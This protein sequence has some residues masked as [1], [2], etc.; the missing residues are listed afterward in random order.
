MVVK[1]IKSTFYHESETKN[2]LCDFIRKAGQL[3]MG[4]ECKKFEAAFAQKQQRKYSVFVS[5][6]S[7]ANLV[8]LQAL[9]NLGRLKK[10]DRVGVSSVTWATNVMPV[11]QLGLD[12]VLIDCELDT[13]NVSSA[14]L[15]SAGKGLK[16]LFLTNVLG[17]CSD[18]DKIALYCKDQGIILLEDNCESLGSKYKGTLLG[19]FGVASTFSFF[20]GHHLSTI[21]GG[22]VCTDDEDLAEML[23]IVRA[24][25]WDR[26]LSRESQQRIRSKH[27]ID[28]FFALYTFYDLAYNARPTEINGFIGNVQLPYWDEI[29]KKRH[30]NFM[31]IRKCCTDRDIFPLKNDRMD[32]ISNFAYPF[33][34]KS[35]ASFRRLKE[36]FQSRDVEIRPVIAGNIASHPFYRKY[37][38]DRSSLPNASVVHA[39]GFYCGNN[40]E[41]SKEDLS[42][43]KSALLGISS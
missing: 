11:I 31:Y 29:V 36:S 17:L 16:A 1:L 12:P 34:C 8:L 28:D 4:A 24:H 35:D 10:G 2:L 40:P 21:E 22:M 33:V 14:T 27:K 23:V 5:S 37:V 43:I 15:K 30:D 20:V 39:C 3:S 9:L 26:N 25:G 42:T 38:K 7:S 6:G 32:I 19:N 13:L 41:M 18:I